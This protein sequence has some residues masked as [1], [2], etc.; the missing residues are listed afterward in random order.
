RA[1]SRPVRLPEIGSRATQDLVLLLQQP[2]P[3]T[4]I[5]QLGGLLPGRAG[6][7][8]VLDISLTHPVRQA[9]LRDPEVLRDLGELLARFTVPRDT[10]DVVAELLGVRSGHDAHPSLRRCSAPQIM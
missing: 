1:F 3:A 10:D 6:T 9:R 8:T 7:G 2:I 4:Q 5:P